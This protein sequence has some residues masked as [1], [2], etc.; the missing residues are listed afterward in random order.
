MNAPTETVSCLRW[1]SVGNWLAASSWSKEV[2]IWNVNTSLGSTTPTA[3]ISQTAPVLSCDW[4]HSG[5]TVFHGACDGGVR[6]SIIDRPAAPATATLGSHLAPIKS[7]IWNKTIQTVISGSWDKT[8]RFFDP[9]RHNTSAATSSNNYSASE[10]CEVTVLKMSERVHSMDNRDHLLAIATADR[11][12][13]LYDLRNLKVPVRE[14]T[15]PLLEKTSTSLCIF[16]DGKSFALGSIEGRVRIEYIDDAK[17]GFAFRC[18]KV[19][20][21][22]AYGVNAMAVTDAHDAMATAGGDGSF[23]FWD[24]EKRTKLRQFERLSQPITACCFS[25]DGHIFAYATGYDWS[26]G[27]QHYDKASAGSQI[28]LHAIVD[29][30][31]ISV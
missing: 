28:F 8:V 14:Y 22:D 20:A 3:I 15:T 31:E 9:R 12:V 25:R 21:Y 29:P 7:V 1:S 10:S 16:P 13:N 23:A 17:K 26:K 24:K 2:R 11:A 4:N 6:M 30:T 5:N 19:G 27:I 18:H